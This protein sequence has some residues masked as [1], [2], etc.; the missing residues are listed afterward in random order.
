MKVL[1]SRINALKKISKIC[2]FK[3]RKMIAN[4]IFLSK[5]IYLIQLWGSSSQFLLNIMQRMQNKAA[6]HVTKLDRFT[7]IKVL[8]NQCGWL[9]VRQLAVYH[10]I[11]QVYKVRKDKKPRYF[12]NKFSTQFTHK[13]R[14]LSNEGIKYTQNITSEPGIQ[15]FSFNAIAAWNS[16]PLSLKRIEKIDTFKKNAKIWIKANIAIE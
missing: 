16:L 11:L 1:T 3:T 15:S 8:L 12:H 7:P 9:S 5:L 10:N 13:T 14:L 4:G 6:R 2:S